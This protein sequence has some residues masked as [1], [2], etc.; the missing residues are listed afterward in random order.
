LYK[1]LVVGASGLLGHDVCHFLRNDFQAVGTYH[2]HPFQTEGVEAVR[3][4]LLSVQ[5]VDAVVRSV[6][7]DILVLCSAMT[8]VDGCEDN[9]QLADELNH[10]AV[11]RVVHA[12]EGMHTKLVHVS[13]DYV[14]SG[15]QGRPYIETDPPTPRSVYGRTKLLGEGVAL[16]RRDALVVRVSSVWGPAPRPGRDNFATWVI[17]TLKAG[18]QVRLFSDQRV[19]PTYTGSFA[20]LLPRILEMNLSGLYHL[21][22]RDCVSRL[23]TGRVLAQ[24]FGL[25]E[26][27]L[28]PARLA[29]A[30]L[31]AHRPPMSCLSSGRLER[32]LGVEMGTY[33][34]DVANFYARESKALIG[35][36]DGA[37]KGGIMRERRHPRR[38]DR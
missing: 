17:G 28:L 32:E 9:P 29:D 33:A 30:G 31:K 2:A 26:D 16:A 3:M 38:R 19:T 11:A 4:N 25:D 27:L 12:I 37:T 5:E 7:P 35:V 36:K 1:L 18:K 13:T 21:S 22:A 10:R 8:A 24:H 20:M 15:S 23:E 34:D 6:R 14:F